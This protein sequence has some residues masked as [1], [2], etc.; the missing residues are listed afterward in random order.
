MPFSVSPVAS[1]YLKTNIDSFKF[2]CWYNIQQQSRAK[3]EE[4]PWIYTE[5]NCSDATTISHIQF[6]FQCYRCGG[7]KYHDSVRNKSGWNSARRHWIQNDGGQVLHPSGTIACLLSAEHHHP[8]DRPVYFVGI[9]LFR[10]G[11]IWWKV[12]AV[13]HDIAVVLGVPPHPL[14]K[15]SKHI[16]E[17]PCLG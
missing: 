2:K 15:H 14:R 13:H 17:P 3:A 9:H 8:H 12:V 1:F 10:S 4:T 7:Q 11:G 16:P 5:I 6:P